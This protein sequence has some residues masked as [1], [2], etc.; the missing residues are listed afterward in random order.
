MSY[1]EAQ[2]VSPDAIPSLAT[3]IFSHLQLGAHVSL[4]DCLDQGRKLLT[5]MLPLDTPTT[6]DQYQRQQ[7]QYTQ[8]AATFGAVS[9][10]Q[11]PRGG[12]AMMLETDWHLARSPSYQSPT[13]PVVF[14][15][16]REA[17][18]KLQREVESQL[19]LDHDHPDREQRYPRPPHPRQ[20]Q[21]GPHCSCLIVTVTGPVVQVGL[22]AGVSDSVAHS[23]KPASRTTAGGAALTAPAHSTLRADAPRGSAPARKLI[24]EC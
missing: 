24:S 20:L 9:G 1:S 21:D 4:Q 19:T 12:N 22:K 11:Q 6:L 2:P 23:T 3:E 17:T 7:Q 13:P 10:H 14:R 18:Q 15:L 16:Q 8:L 5:H